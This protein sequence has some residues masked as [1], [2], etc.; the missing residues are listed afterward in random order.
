[1]I[2]FWNF[3]KKYYPLIFF[4]IIVVMSV[5]LFQTCST[6]NKEREDRAFQEKIWNQ[7]M[8]A[9]KDSI[10]VEF[11][12]KLGAYE[13]SKDNYVLEKLK[14]L[15]KYNKDLYNQLNKVKGD[16]IAAIDARV[17]GDLGGLTAGNELV[18]IDKKTNNYGLKFKSHYSDDSFEQILEG[19][20]KFYAYPDESNKNWLLKPDTTLFSTN[21]TKLKI[22]YGFRD[23]KD[24]YEVFAVSSSPKIEIDELNGVFVLEKQPLPPAPRPKKW[25][26]GPYIGFGL[27]TDFNLDNPRFGWS[28]GF[29]LHY[30]IFQWR[31]GKK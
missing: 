10:T 8:S 11:N 31:F 20:S 24:K 13:I 19:I 21:I 7:N 26:I 18:V 23:L 15:E 4:G 2:A 27:N 3:I 12:K 30:D 28:V 25:A 29:S 14:D 9:L 17:T 5:F 6:L 1:M 16:L 22:T